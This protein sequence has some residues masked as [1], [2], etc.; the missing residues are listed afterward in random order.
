MSK[1][2][3]AA[4]PAEGPRRDLAEPIAIRRKASFG[5]KVAGAGICCAGVGYLL[6]STAISTHPIAAYVYGAML[7]AAAVYGLSGGMQAAIRRPA[8]LLISKDGIAVF[9]RRVPHLIQWSDIKG[10]HAATIGSGRHRDEIVALQLVD[11]QSFHAR[12]YADKGRW[13]WPDSRKR[14]NCYPI[15]T[16]GLDVSR[17]ELIELVDDGIRRWGT[18][19]PESQPQTIYAV[20]SNWEP[21][22]ASLIAILLI[23]LVAV[24]ALPFALGSPPRWV[25]AAKDCDVRNPYGTKQ[26]RSM[27]AVWTGPC[28]DGRADGE[29]TLEWFLKGQRTERYSGRM[30]GGRITGRGERTEYETMWGLGQLMKYEV[31]YDGL[32]KDGVL[33]EG[34]MTFPDERQY[35]GT[36]K[37][38]EWAT[39]I[40]TMPGGWQWEGQWHAGRLTGEGRAKGRQ[41][42]FKGHWTNGIPQG[43][44][45]FVTR[46]GRRFEGTWEDGKPVDAEMAHLQEQ[47]R[48]DCLWTVLPGRYD[49]PIR[50]EPW[51]CRIR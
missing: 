41:G 36:W 1:P 8:V 32:W 2:V 6:W 42:E 23:V 28:V 35:R 45:V 40:L 3:I 29:G 39:G 13:F 20:F 12:F 26:W 48:W 9:R 44:G 37:L 24:L 38:G 27:R 10:A 19:D 46:D 51:G 43:A 15:S 49:T 25:E 50:T 16:D 7:I 18:H 17:P 4:T 30:E 5:W 11:P 21:L 22:H 14:P 33:L 31:R 47:E 34:T